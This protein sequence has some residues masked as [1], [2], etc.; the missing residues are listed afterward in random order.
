MAEYGKAGGPGLLERRFDLHGQIA[1]L[2][3][4]DLLPGVLIDRSF[5]YGAAGSSMVKW[6]PP[7]ADAAVAVP[8]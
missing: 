3:Q 2:D 7:K 5:R 6:L 1:R 4:A 8:P